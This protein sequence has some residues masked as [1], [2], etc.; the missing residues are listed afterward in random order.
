MADNFD[1]DK[2]LA[3]KAGASFDPDQYLKEK[4]LPQESST[5]TWTPT[6]SV[7][8]GALQ[9]ATAGFSDELG[10]AM[11]AL[12]E[13]VL[14]SGNADKK[15][16]E[17]LYKEYRDMHR[18]RNKQAEEQNPK[19]NFAGNVLGSIGSAVIAPEA[20]AAKATGIGGAAALGA[21]SGLGTSEATDVSGDIKNTALGGVLGAGAGAIGK[22]IGNLVNPE[23]LDVMASKA[24]SKAVGIKSSKELTSVYDKATGKMTSGSDV[25]KGIGKTALDEGALPMT[26]GAENIYDKSI[27]AINHQYD[28]LNP[29]VVNAQQKLNQNLPQHLEAAGSINNK[30]AQF[31]DDF[32][33]SLDTNPDQDAIMKKIEDKYGPYIQKISQS[34]GDLNQLVQYKRG[35]QDYAQ[36]LSA[37]AYSNPASDLKPE[38]A[39]VKQFGGVLRQH[40]EDLASS[41]DQ[42]SGQEMGQINKTLGNLYT[43]KDAAKKLMDKS[44]SSV[45]YKDALPGAASYAIGGPMGAAAYGA[46]KIGL[47]AATGNPLSRIANMAK[48]KAANQMSKAVQTPAG[49]LVQKV[50]PNAP[51]GVVTNPFSQKAVQDR[52]KNEGISGSSARANDFDTTPMSGTS[53]AQK[54]ATN[55]YTATDDSLKEVASNLS[56]DPMT[57]FYGEHLNKAIDSND[58]AEKNRAVFLILQNP[59]S[60]R[61]VMPIKK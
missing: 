16:L 8:Q 12:Q 30:A 52:V 61:L 33:N 23:N 59:K 3:E 39:F 50:V 37:A 1:P 2:Y 54:I 55:L 21:A 51:L 27:D 28:K 56:K 36:D 44:S 13:K 34:D 19:A 46:G 15:S 24:A 11:G 47:E 20:L 9:G 29:I 31:M 5:P 38:A 10:G 7:A 53:E 35:V 43:Y 17:D 58:Q 57:K 40:I 32:R 14:P 41:A 6:E 45:G 25:I 18:G 22:G 26:G 49:E 42:G 48:A 60:R 4:G